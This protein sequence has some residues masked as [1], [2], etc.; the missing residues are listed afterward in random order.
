MGHLAVTARE[1]GDLCTEVANSLADGVISDNELARV[2]RECGELM[3]SLRTLRDAL[4][5]HCAAGKPTDLKG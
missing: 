5:Q 3:A 4:A 1:F 2:D